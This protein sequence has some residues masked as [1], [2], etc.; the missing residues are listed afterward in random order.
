MKKIDLRGMRASLGDIYSLRDDHARGRLITLGSTLAVSFY[1]VF[2]TGIFH[3]GFLSMYGISI[4]GVGIIT[5]IPF[6]ASCF[7]IFSSKI[8]GPIPRRK[9]VLVGSKIFFYALYIVGATLMPQFVIDPG[10]RLTWFAIIMF[11][12]PRK[13]YVCSA[14]EDDWADPESEY[15]GCAAAEPAWTLHRVPGLAAPD[16]LPEV[17]V[18]IH[19]G[20]VCYHLRAGKHFFSRT[21][22]QH[23]LCCREKFFI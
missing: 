23:Q 16:A 4:T 8:L 12:A 19:R 22:W 13:L 2:I 3:T 1:N 17:G 7:S 6:I 10:A 15:L 5:F 20:G 14:A 21:D 18:P 9:A 11:V